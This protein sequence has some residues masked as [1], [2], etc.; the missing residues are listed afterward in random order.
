MSEDNSNEKKYNC[1]CEASFASV[2][3]LDKHNHEAH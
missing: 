2:E 3:E 1:Q